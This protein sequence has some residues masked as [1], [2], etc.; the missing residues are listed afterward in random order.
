MKVAAALGPRVEKL[1]L[2]E[3]NPFTL[4]DQTGRRGAFA[5]CLALRDAVKQAGASGDWK[6]AAEK[7]A[8]YWGGAGAW[9]AMPDE[10][11]AVFV[12]GLKPNFHE[13][14]A[15]LGETI[16]LQDWA[17]AL[18][19]ATLVVS[20]RETARPIREIVELMREACPHWRFEQIDGGGH[21][22]PLT[23]PD[24]INPIVW[25]FLKDPPS[26]PDN[27][28]PYAASHSSSQ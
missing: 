6:V 19:E 12:E 16:A 20:A 10:R 26:R 7:F 17:P 8:D 1:I 22:A 21:M 24:L 18:P 28:A 5:E 23:H 3:P 25:S 15:V 9:A 11:R 2:L 13:W 4:L 14:D 27:R